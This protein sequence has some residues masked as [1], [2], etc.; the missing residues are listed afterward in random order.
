[1]DGLNRNNE[2]NFKFKT[3]WVTYS[4]NVIKARS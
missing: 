3:K 2:I 1:M 4:S